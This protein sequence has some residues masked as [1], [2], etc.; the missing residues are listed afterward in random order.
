MSNGRRAGPGPRMRLLGPPLCGVSREIPPGRTESTDFGMAVGGVEYG[1]GSAL[2]V[3]AAREIAA[4]Q[5]L[6]TL[7]AARR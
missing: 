4:E 2:S 1:R 7:W 5:A 6:R 3:G